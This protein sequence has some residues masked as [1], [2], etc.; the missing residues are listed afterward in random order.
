MSL[1]IISMTLLENN[2]NN[3]I[4]GSGDDADANDFT[5]E[6]DD[7]GE[8]LMTLVM[9]ILPVMTMIMVIHCRKCSQC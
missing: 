5:I 9:V 2:G 3:G 7:A 6:G 1:L 8:N 4:I